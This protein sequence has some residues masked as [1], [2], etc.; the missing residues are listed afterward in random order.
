[1]TTNF[2][3]ILLS[4]IICFASLFVSINHVANSTETKDFFGGYVKKVTYC[5]CYYN[6]GVVLEIDDYSNNHQTLKV[7]Y[8]VLLSRLWANYNVWSADTYVIGGYTIGVGTCENT[9]TWKCSNSDT[10]PDGM[11]DYVR[12]IGTS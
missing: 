3:L 2:K 10:Q 4:I 12:G 7:F 9:A 5:S 1:M 6:P 11:V 8:S